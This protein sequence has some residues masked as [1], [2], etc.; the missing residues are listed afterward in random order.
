MLTIFQPYVTELD[1]RH[2][3]IA[4]ELIGDLRRTMPVHSGISEL[5]EDGNV[6]KYDYVKFMENLANG[7]K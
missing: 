5:R 4:E 7:H 2:S 6:V 1:L 3:L